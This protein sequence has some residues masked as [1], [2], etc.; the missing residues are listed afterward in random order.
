[1]TAKEESRRRAG[2][3]TLRLPLVMRASEC[4][5]R[6]LLAAALAGAELF[7]GH[8]LFGLA[9][10]GSAGAGGE[11]FA[12]LLGAALGYLSF[13][14]FLDGLR[15]IASAMMIFAVSMALCDFQI[16]RRPWFMPLVSAALNGVVGF[17]YLSAG[18]WN[19]ERAIYFATEV[20][21]TAA[22]VYFYRLAFSVWEEKREDGCLSVKQ[23]VGILVLGCTLLM[24]LSGVT[25]GD[26]SVGRVLAAAAVMV[27]GWKGGVGVGAAAG[28]AAGLA[29]DLSAMA[30]PYYTMAYGFA[31]LV[32]GVFSKQGRLLS[33]AAYVVSSGAAVLWNWSGSGQL[34]HM[35]EVAAASVIFLLLPDK[36][37]RRFAALTRQEG[38]HEEDARTRRYTAGQLRRTADAFRAVSAGVKGLYAAPA[39]DGDA[40]KLFD[41]AAERVCLNCTQ[42]A[43]CWQRDYQATRAALNDALPRLLDQGTGESGD[44]PGYFSARCIHFPAFLGEVNTELERLL[45][46]RM[47][48]SRVRESRAAVCAQYDQLAQVLDRCAH[49]VG[50]D[51]P[52]DVRRQR[53][54]KQRLAALGLEGRCAVFSDEHG[55]LRLELD[56]K[57]VEKLAQPEEL[58]GLDQLMGCALRVEESGK[59]RLCLAQKEP[60]LAVAGVSALGRDGMPVS[61]D[62]GAWFKDGA[63]QLYFLL[64]DGMGSGLAARQD[65][66]GALRLLEKFLRAGQTPQEALGTVGEAL[67]L[68]GE[69]DGG[70]TTVDLL[71]IDLFT[72]Q[73]AVY[74]L[75]AAPTYLRRG[76]QVERLS[77][78]SLPAGLMAQ[79][80][81]APD[82]FPLTLKPG[83]CVVMVS[84]GVSNG[85]EDGWLIQALEQ[86]DG[87]SP[88]ALAQQL[89]SGSRDRAGGDD[90]TVI[91]VKMDVRG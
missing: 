79:E 83:D 53:Q 21:M 75:G 12:A 36:L 69:A 43:L 9:M 57:D 46:R 5:I 67:A 56:G 25:V 13:R 17:V 30:S 64:C 24:T 44:F 31:G 63:G 50:S 4:V 68:K 59:G 54:L 3:R 74:K 26:V 77:A 2:R 16:Y 55:H 51:L 61:G 84:D 45:T 20:V 23:T 86:F 71:Q 88:Q 87:L 70:F 65:S 60:L 34:G 35:Y 62:S 41:R 29:M 33:M 52:V 22:A 81:E 91:V 39:N 76:G 37:L 27:A 47:Y 89:L 82:V 66:D 42:S 8:A 7:Q 90:R 14:G 78:A 73:S 6:F 10:V 85:R 80:G 18:G 58:K 32:T 15:Y 1:M 38:A 19:T 49:Q 28:V 48:D 40:A 11:G 72:G